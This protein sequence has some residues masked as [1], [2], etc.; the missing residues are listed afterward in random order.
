MNSVLDQNITIAAVVGLSV[1]VLT[2]CAYYFSGGN[3]SLNASNS[4]K[5]TKKVTSVDKS[6]TQTAIG[7]STEKDGS[8][9]EILRGY[10]KLDN[11]KVTTYFNRELS[12]K[13]KG[14]K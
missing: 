6:K 11:G 9:N 7:N 3:K 10:K 14:E 1:V 8:K 2:G 5:K 4:P 12:T 13:D